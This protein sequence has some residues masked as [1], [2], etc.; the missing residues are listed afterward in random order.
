MKLYI[1]LLCESLH[2]Y[3]IQ[4]QFAEWLVGNYNII[5]SWLFGQLSNLSENANKS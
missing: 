3:K 5:E 1:N 4:V 2:K